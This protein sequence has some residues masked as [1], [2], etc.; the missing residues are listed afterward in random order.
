MDARWTTID[1]DTNAAAVGFAKSSDAKNV[2]ENVAHAGKNVIPSESR[3]IPLRKLKG[4]ITG[5]LDCARDDR[6]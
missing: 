6:G 5:S 4:N 3:G 1:H 2:A